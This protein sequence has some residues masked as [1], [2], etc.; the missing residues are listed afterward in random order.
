MRS[1]ANR[2]LDRWWLKGGSILKAGRRFYALPGGLMVRLEL[3]PRPGRVRPRWQYSPVRWLF[4]IITVV[5]VFI[6][7]LGVTSWRESRPNDDER[8][9]DE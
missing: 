4:L 9:D 1:W 7:W 3:C 6:Y 5:L 8:E 2:L